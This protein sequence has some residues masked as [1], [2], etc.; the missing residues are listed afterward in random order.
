MSS[1]PGT[2]PAF[3]P[4]AQSGYETQFVFSEGDVR[5]S[6]A[7]DIHRVVVGKFTIP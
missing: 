1:R 2:P 7:D 4:G 6:D 5:N 3:D